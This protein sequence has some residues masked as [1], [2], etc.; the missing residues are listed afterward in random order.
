MTPPK[1]YDAKQCAEVDSQFFFSGTPWEIT[2]RRYTA[3]AI[4]MGYGGLFNT[5]LTQV[6]YANAMEGIGVLQAIQEYYVS[7]FDFLPSVH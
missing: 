7:P 4:N 1:I 6:T 5:T 3:E 2:T